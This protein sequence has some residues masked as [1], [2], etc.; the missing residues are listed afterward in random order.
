MAGVKDPIMFGLVHDFF[1]VYL[2]KMLNRSPNTIIAYREALG[3]LFDFVKADKGICLSEV[4]FEMIDHMMIAKFLD[5]LEIGRGC[6]IETRNHRLNRI[7]A[8]Y[9]YAAKME[10]T[11][12]IH[13][14][15]IL[16]VPLKKSTKPDIVEH[17]SED[18]VK[19]ILAQPDATTKKGLRDQFFMILLYDTAARIQEIMGI[20]FCDIKLGKTP[21][22]TLH[23]KGGKTRIVPLMES[24]VEHFH[25]YAKVFHPGEGTYSEQY[26]FYV[27]RHGQKNKMHHDNARRFIYDYGVAAKKQYHEVP[28]VVHPHLFRHSRAMHL[29]QHGME[30]TLLAQWL[31]HAKIETSRIYYGKQADTEQKRRAIANATDKNSPLASKLNADRFTVSDDDILKQLYGLKE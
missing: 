13:R 31:G 17:M 12:V 8:F 15:E 26:L 20:R 30:L 1:Q 22:V 6:T 23:G 29:Y 3:A 24:T 28:D 25:N 11:A 27:V 9:K 21:K 18:A 14:N 16:K 19:A 7:R 2:S 10:P 4:T 5:H